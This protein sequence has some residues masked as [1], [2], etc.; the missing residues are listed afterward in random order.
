MIAIIDYNMGNVRSVAKAFKKLNADFIISNSPQDIKKATHLVLPGVGAFGDGMANLKKLKLIELLEEEA[1]KKKKPFLGI[2]IGMQ[3][4]ASKGEEH[5]Q[6]YGLGWIK[7]TVRRFVVD[8]KRYK[9]P[10]L[11]WNNITIRTQKPLFSD[12][13]DASDFYFV[14]SFHLVPED[15]RVIAATCDYGETFVAAIKKDNIFGVQ[16]HPEKSQTYGIKVI[17]NFIHA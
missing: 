1:L 14:H 15:Q 13:P 5:G 11:G 12:I 9:V 3:L 10:H 6:H 16:F 4:L 17:E 2:C 8:E 7:G